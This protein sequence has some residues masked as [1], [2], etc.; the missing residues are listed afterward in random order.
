MQTARRL[1]N[2]WP[3]QFST[4]TAP[5]AL[6]RIA[7]CSASANMIAL[8]HASCDE[9]S[10]IAVRGTHRRTHRRRVKSR[11]FPYLGFTTAM[12]KSS[13]DR[14]CA[15]ARRFPQEFQNAQGWQDTGPAQALTHCAPVRSA[16][17]CAQGPVTP[18]LTKFSAVLPNTRG[19]KW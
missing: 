3:A 17:R 11:K 9:R 16:R 10:H 2:Q 1:V 4:Q 18:S 15:S 12:M 13:K 19:C 6:S 8:S 14:H 7:A 5:P